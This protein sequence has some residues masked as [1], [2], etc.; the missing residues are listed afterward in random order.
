M[1]II[2]PT[3][4]LGSRHSQLKEV[5]S[6]TAAGPGFATTIYLDPGYYLLAFSA[7]TTGLNG[8]GSLSFASIFGQVVQ[9]YPLAITLIDG[10]TSGNSLLIDIGT[11]IYYGH[12][13]FRLASGILRPVLISQGLYMVYE[14]GNTSSGTLTINILGVFA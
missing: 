4:Q 10:T 7:T 12:I 2:A 11:N 3:V 5:Y 6:G 8:Q 9:K 1:S 13:N 14:G